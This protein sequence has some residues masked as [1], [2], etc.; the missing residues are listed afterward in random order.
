MVIPIL[1][2][3]LL[4]FDTNPTLHLQNQSLPQSYSLIPS[5][6]GFGSNKQLQTTKNRGHSH[7]TL[8]FF[9]LLELNPV[10]V[11]ILTL[12]RAQNFYV[13][14]RLPHFLHQPHNTTRFFSDVDPMERFMTTGIWSS[15]VSSKVQCCFSVWSLSFPYSLPTLQ[16]SL[17]SQVS[18]SFPS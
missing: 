15:R 8:A 11:A 5:T 1:A 18:I 13:Q 2:C 17:Q 12:V 3:V 4:S 9:N 6:Y 7:C 16:A 14:C 10:I